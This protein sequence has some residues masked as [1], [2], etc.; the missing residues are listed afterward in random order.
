MYFKVST[1]NIED[2]HDFGRGRYFFKKDISIS[3]NIKIDKLDYIKI[4]NFFSSKVSIKRI[5][6]RVI[7]WEKL[8]VIHT[9]KNLHLAYIKNFYNLRRWTI[10]LLGRKEDIQMDNKLLKVSQP[11]SP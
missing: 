10:G 4:R 9:T 5:K 6:M 3:T 7:K 1:D 2:L 11:H 8:F